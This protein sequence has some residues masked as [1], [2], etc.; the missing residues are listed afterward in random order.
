MHYNLAF[1]ALGFAQL[2]S[3]LANAQG[4]CSSIATRRDITSLSAQEWSRMESVLNRM[5]ADGWFQRFADIHNR[6]FGNIHGNDNF[7]PWHRRFLRDFEEVG[8][9][10]DPSF[11]VPYWDELRDSRSPASSRV[12]TSRLL[13][14]NGFGG[15]VKD[16]LEAGWTLGFPSSHCLVRQYD[17]G[18]QMQ[19][20]YSPEFIYS[21]M[22]RYNDMHGFREHIEYSIHGSVHLS[23][24]GDMATYWSPNDFIF[25][26]HHANLDRLWD[27]WQMSGHAMTM[28]GTNQNGSP[29]SLGLPLPHYGDPV[30]STMRMGVGRMCFRY[31]G[32][33]GGARSRSASSQLALVAAPL[34]G[35]LASAD[36]G[37]S[38]LP[39]PV[40]EKWFPA[41]ARQV[42]P[43]AANATA[44]SSPVPA[45][46]PKPAS[47]ALPHNSTRGVI[48]SA[49]NPLLYPAP[50]TEMWISMHKLNRGAVARVMAEARQFVSDLNNVN[51]NSPY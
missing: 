12:L 22:Q 19:S 39:R 44:K 16:G 31:A 35:D 49:K 33:G 6:E 13:G 50:L 15:C 34:R 17:R 3:R 25:F 30:G 23:V 45:P 28:D 46:K 51:Y 24:G 7:F 48:V 26:L 43:P 8:Q 21:V 2:S 11:A 1:L 40:L 10:Y 20:W 41:L 18:D 9:T 38:R 47:S 42:A 4:G 14:G 36:A 29:M 5:Q 37:L 27:Q 32:N